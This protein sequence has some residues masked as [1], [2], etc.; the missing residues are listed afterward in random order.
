MLTVN[1][2]KSDILTRMIIGNK[3]GITVR[4]VTVYVGSQEFHQ[5]SMTGLNQ[6]M[7]IDNFDVVHVR[8][9]NYYRIEIEVV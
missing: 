9:N 6:S 8:L 3:L 5:L 4:K 1:Q 2:V 7:K